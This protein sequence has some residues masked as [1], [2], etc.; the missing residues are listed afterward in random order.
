MK[1]QGYDVGV[2]LLNGTCS[3]MR[4]LLCLYLMIFPFEDHN[5]KFSVIVQLLPAEGI[6]S[7]GSLIDMFTPGVGLPILEAVQR[8][9][10]NPPS[11]SSTNPLAM[12]AYNL[13]ER[14][15]LGNIQA[16]FYDGHDHPPS[17]KARLF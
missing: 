11:P 15:D 5:A 9:C 13:I 10:M 14:P 6:R 17:S 16:S 12:D 1:K 3:S 4:V 2:K 7:I 8:C